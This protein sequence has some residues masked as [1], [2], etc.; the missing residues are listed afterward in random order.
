MDTLRPL[1]VAASDSQGRNDPA[2][3]HVLGYH[4]FG[5]N[6]NNVDCLDSPRARVEFGALT[7][8]GLPVKRE[9]TGLPAEGWACGLATLCTG[10]KE[11]SMFEGESLPVRYSMFALTAALVVSSVGCAP[12]EPAKSAEARVEPVPAVSACACAGRAR[13]GGHERAPADTS[14]RLRKRPSVTTLMCAR[15]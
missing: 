13:S 8:E 1:S 5:A 15:R 2:L 12:Q 14:K 6:F 9:R 3:A 11:M 7:V 4:R 10:D